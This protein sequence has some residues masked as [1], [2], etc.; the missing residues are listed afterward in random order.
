MKRADAIKV[1][2]GLFNGFGEL[3][4]TI[5]SAILK[6]N[7]MSPGGTT[8]AGYS[9]LEEANVRNGCMNAVEE[10]FLRTKIL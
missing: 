3:I 7:V 8:A 6:D 4:P 1:T 9:A 10:A 5:H 2:N